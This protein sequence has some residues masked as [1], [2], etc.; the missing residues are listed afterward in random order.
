MLA[1]EIPHASAIIASPIAT[2][3]GQL[4]AVRP[5]LTLQM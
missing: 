3:S 2:P 4:I 1:L 5:L